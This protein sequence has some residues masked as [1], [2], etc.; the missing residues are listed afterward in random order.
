MEVL[1]NGKPWDVPV[2]LL[3]VP[4]SFGDEA[5]IF[6]AHNRRIPVNEAGITQEPL[7]EGADYRVEG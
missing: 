1:I 4:T 3:D 7:V 2:G 6:D 5:A